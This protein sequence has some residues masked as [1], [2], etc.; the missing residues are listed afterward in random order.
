MQSTTRIFLT[1]LPTTWEDYNNYR[2][3]CAKSHNAFML[4]I[5]DAV[6]YGQ[7]KLQ[8]NMLRPDSNPSLTNCIPT[9]IGTNSSGRGS[10]GYDFPLI[11][12]RAE[13]N[14]VNATTYWT[15]ETTRQVLAFSQQLQSDAESC[16]SALQGPGQFFT[17]LERRITSGSASMLNGKLRMTTM[18]WDSKTLPH[19]P[20]TELVAIEPPATAAREEE[21]ETLVA[22][23]E[24]KLDRAIIRSMVVQAAATAAVFVKSV[25]QVLSEKIS[26]ADLVISLRMVVPFEGV[27]Y[28]LFKFGDDYMYISDG[29]YQ[30]IPF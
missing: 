21:L 20:E 24:P 8:T 14:S 18:L 9:I 30:S 2:I 1:D 16:A 19:L 4:A 27:D 12:P 25:E 29:G 11:N 15:I 22:S 13:F 5:C 6:K 10:R 3:Q 23:L 26:W 7:K 28:K 17:G